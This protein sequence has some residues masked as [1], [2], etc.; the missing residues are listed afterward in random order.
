[1]TSQSSFNIQMS[2]GQLDLV[3]LRN[4]EIPLLQHIGKVRLGILRGMDL[5]V[6]YR[7]R[8]GQLPAL[9]H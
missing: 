2:Y 3:A 7:L 1:M 9:T 5:P 6:H 4:P 8:G